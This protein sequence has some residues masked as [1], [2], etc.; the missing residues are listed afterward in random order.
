MKKQGARKIKR[1]IEIVLYV[2]VFTLYF[3]AH[4]VRG[5]FNDMSFEQMIFNMTDTKGGNYE[6][7]FVGAFYVI[8]RLIIVVLIIF[9]I[10]YLYKL[11][12]I[13]IFF[14]VGFKNEIKK[15][16][17]FKRTKLSSI[18]LFLFVATILL[19]RCYKIFAID[20]YIKN[21]RNTTT[22]FEDY[23]VNPKDVD[24]KFPKEKRNLIYIY[25]ESMESTN[26]SK[27]NG[28]YSNTSYIPRLET[29][30]LE[31]ISF[32][33]TDKLGGAYQ[34]NNTNWTIASLISQT[35]GIPLKL[36]TN[37][38]EISHEFPGLYNLGDI[39]KDNGY[40]NYFMI[41]SDAEFGGRKEY[42][43][44]HGDYNIYDYY[45][46]IEDG[47]IDEDYFVWW[48]YEDRK[49]FNY[50]KEKI[51]EAYME[52]EPFNFTILTVDTHFTDG[53][54]DSSCK[55]LFDDPYENALY[56]SDSNVYLFL[57]WLKKQDFYKNTTIILTGDH[58]TMQDNVYEEGEYKRTVYNAFINSKVKPVNEK[59]REF[60]TLD[61]F[62]TTLA[63]L[64]VEIDGNRLGL[65]VNL[66]SKEK[67]LIE[68]LG[69]DYLNEEITKKSL[70]YDNQILEIKKK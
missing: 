15:I 66:F 49:L 63:A 62:P 53:Y 7:V 36:G 31:N 23:Y 17:L 11:L 67:T 64:G 13:K 19:N 29:I 16:E 38:I 61:M 54:L 1:I 47:Y 44:S 39:L 55:E 51:K 24:L 52:D 6:I 28:G 56:C 2:L 32:S 12:K 68:E 65:G 9:G 27:V 14:K 4:F 21:K 10:Y 60:S 25:L 5:R 34:L 35:S 3:V 46:A 40:N 30:A 50:A 20:E 18:L 42:F 70:Y 43:E 48:G 26:V 45:Y 8:I 37:T 33:N 41:G 59:N 22:L 69:F 57:K 58:L